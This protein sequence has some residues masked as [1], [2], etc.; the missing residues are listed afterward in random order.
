[1]MRREC[2]YRCVPVL[3]AACLLLVAGCEEESSP[4]AG[5]TAARDTL[6]TLNP[7]GTNPM[8]SE[9]RAE[10][11][12][13]AIADARRSTGVAEPAAQYVVAEA[14]IGQAAL[15]L[16]TARAQAASLD[17]VVRDAQR[18][19]ARYRDA[20]AR[21][22][23]ARQYDPS[24]DL[25]ELRGALSAREQEIRSARAD[26]QRTLEEGEAIESQAEMKLSESRIARDRER[27]VREQAYQSRGESRARLVTEANGFRRQADLLERDAALLGAQRAA[28]DPRIE[29]LEREVRRLTAQRDS[30]ERSI[31]SVEAFRG[32]LQ[33]RAR[34][35]DALAR[36]LADGIRA[37]IDE[38]VTLLDDGVGS[39]VSA[40]E[41]K[42][43]QARSALNR[44]RVMDRKATDSTGAAIQHTRASFALTH[45]VAASQVSDLL[46][47]AGKADP[48]L[49]T[50]DEGD[51]VASTLESARR[52]AAEALNEAQ[53]NFNRAGDQ[54]ARVSS[55]LQALRA[56]LLGEETAQ[57]ESDDDE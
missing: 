53:Q 4:V 37:S 18:R 45:L 1:M 20:A 51:R 35:D 48:S 28:L 25:S 55:R 22:A 27:S 34:E 17:Q 12:Q 50:G 30:I 19:I 43:D 16:E 13:K 15:D 29:S 52:S 33:G 21:A 11:Y 31:E 8:P 23:S 26:V 2:D 7:D 6:I 56:A 10:A 47:V 5:V 46:R 54:G 14:T 9:V 3:A 44:S 39:S 32:E 49:V 38:A 36:S 40:G 41:S 42:L 57:D 24:R